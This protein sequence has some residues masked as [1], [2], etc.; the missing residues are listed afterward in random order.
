MKVM[1][2]GTVEIEVREVETASLRAQEDSAGVWLTGQ[3]NIAWRALDR[4]WNYKTV[5]VAGWNDPA[6][7]AGNQIERDGVR[8]LWRIITDSDQRSLLQ[9]EI[10][11][12]LLHESVMELGRNAHESLRNAWVEEA[13]DVAQ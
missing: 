5:S 3:I 9:G 12:D 2:I 7:E 8:I 10:L 13:A 11:N 4:W 1:R 6:S